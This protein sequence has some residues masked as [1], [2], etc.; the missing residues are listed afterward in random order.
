MMNRPEAIN[1][2][3]FLIDDNGISHLLTFDYFK[4]IDDMNQYCDEKE[5]EKKEL[6]ERLNKKI[7]YL[8]NE[9]ASL[10][11]ELNKRNKREFRL[12]SARNRLSLKLEEIGMCN[13]QDISDCPP[14]CFMCWN[15]WSMQDE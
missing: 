4:F 8:E 2:K 11:K 5:Q 7:E 12:E 1:Y 15:I 14:H 13:K 9:R 6:E 3:T 10:I